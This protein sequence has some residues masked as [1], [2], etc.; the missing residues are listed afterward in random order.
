VRDGSQCL[1][2]ELIGPLKTSKQAASDDDFRN[3]EKV[4]KRKVIDR[5]VNEPSLLG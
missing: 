5:K 4:Q 1:K 3:V 2:K